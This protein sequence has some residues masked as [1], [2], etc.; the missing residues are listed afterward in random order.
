MH[1]KMARTP[2]TPV[3][4]QFSVAMQQKTPNTS[5]NKA[6]TLVNIEYATQIEHHKR[7]LMKPEFDEDDYD[8][9]KYPDEYWNIP[10]QAMLELIQIGVH[11][12]TTYIDSSKEEY[13][14]WAKGHNGALDK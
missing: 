5:E 4:P 3:P 9:S 13:E 7:I 2:Q 14:I 1:S 8:F 6:D 11:A 10:N 12:V